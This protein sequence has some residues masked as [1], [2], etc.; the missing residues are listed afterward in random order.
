MLDLESVLGRF[1]NDRTVLEL[2]AGVLRIPTGDAVMSE[3][4]GVSGLTQKAPSMPSSKGVLDAGRHAEEVCRHLDSS[5]LYTGVASAVRTALSLYDAHEEWAVG[6]GDLED[7]HGRDAITRLVGLGL[8]AES[9][10]EGD[11]DSSTS[12]W[13]GTE[14]GRAALAW[15]AAV[16]IVL[17]FSTQDD[18]IDGDKLIDLLDLFFDDAISAWT[19]LT[20]PSSLARSR[21]IVNNWTDALCPAITA[22][23]PHVET[24]ADTVR[25]LLPSD[26]ESH[27]SLAA[28]AESMRLY[29]ALCARHL[30]ETLNGLDS[31]ANE[32]DSA[33]E[34]DNND[35]VKQ[36]MAE[37]VEHVSMAQDA[38]EQSKLQ[39][40]KTEASIEALCGQQDVQVATR[41]KTIDAIESAIAEQKG[42]QGSTPSGD[43]EGLSQQA[44]E[45]QA[46]LVAAEAG[47]QSARSHRDAVNL[48]LTHAVQELEL[49]PPVE[50][51]QSNDVDVAEEK[52]AQ[53]R[54]DL[55][56]HEALV[57]S[58]KGDV[59]A[60]EDRLHAAV[61]RAKARCA[62]VS[63][64][65]E[66][67]R[68]HQA[69][70]D[71]KLS[72]LDNEATTVTA[73]RAKLSEQM[74]RLTAQRKKLGKKGQSAE[75]GVGLLVASVSDAGQE[76]DVALAQHKERQSDCTTKQERLAAVQQAH[77]AVRE[78]LTGTIESELEAAQRTLGIW[79][80]IQRQ[81]T[82]RV[83]LYTA[84]LDIH[85]NQMDALAS[86]RGETKERLL[87][88]RK[89]R[90]SVGRTQNSSSKTVQ[91]KL[92]EIEENQQDQSAARKE[93]KRRLKLMSKAEEDV[94]RM[95][96][97][98]RKREQR[99]VDTHNA[100]LSKEQF[101][102]ELGEQITATR[103][104]LEEI[105]EGQIRWRAAEEELRL[106]EV[107]EVRRALSVAQAEW[108]AADQLLGPLRDAATALNTRLET[109]V[110]TET[111]HTKLLEACR[112]R[113]QEKRDERSV[114]GSRYDHGQ[115]TAK[116]AVEMLKN[117]ARRLEDS[118]LA[119]N[120][121]Q[122]AL[123]SLRSKQG[124]RKASIERWGEQII[125]GQRAE[126]MAKA[127]I[128]SCSEAIEQTRLA[129]SSTADAIGV[130]QRNV[131][132]ARLE[133]VAELGEQIRQ[134]K[135]Q[136]KVVQQ[137]IDE[138]RED[139][140]GLVVA[141]ER[142]VA[143][144][145]SLSTQ[146]Q[147]TKNKIAEV[148]K[149][150]VAHQKRQN[151]VFSV[152][153]E[154]RQGLEAVS[155]G[156]A[157]AQLTIRALESNRTQRAKRVERS[158]GRLTQLDA[159]IELAQ[160]QEEDA[161]EAVADI[162]SWVDRSRL[163]LRRLSEEQNKQTESVGQPPVVPPAKDV[164]TQAKVDKPIH[165]PKKRIPVGLSEIIP[166]PG[167]A[168]DV[169][170]A[171]TMRFV[172]PPSSSETDMDAATAIFDRTPSSSADEVHDE[173]DAATLIF[174]REELRA[175]LEAEEDEDARTSIISIE[176]M[177]AQRNRSKK[178]D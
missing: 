54:R 120:E 57:A 143:S 41:L 111:A 66:R 85:V 22:C 43:L 134:A 141:E 82:S 124:S 110:S 95:T 71:K 59:A 94:V 17:A 166:D 101:V 3:Y 80:E 154:R 102:Q 167:A 8:V 104:A 157:G 74:D 32:L 121:M 107:K 140:A 60:N 105:R 64:S 78:M 50:S 177:K 174:S 168:L 12:M 81:K 152:I 46:K 45:S 164:K 13:L 146:V 9:L 42:M 127:T 160:A 25:L 99:A 159:M 100:V 89:E 114:L 75:D 142:V 151:A 72:V 23:A 38:L 16:E 55:E 112:L 144:Q 61:A 90:R 76:L 88:V 58:A 19:D 40:E 103:A 150:R 137:T 158:L 118:H 86:N 24:I 44:E 149:R 119:R 153:A 6:I 115:K 169:D 97:N 14:S 62:D 84:Q 96:K 77:A 70:S 148:N 139:L 69:E 176:E 122:S 135:T 156:I 163:N 4:G 53:C 125:E 48:A 91:A 162:Q 26:V 27:D 11:S 36:A 172:S 132:E 47:L 128:E 35:A 29:L 92:T 145:S 63:E 7:E 51:L 65:M 73:S 2:L 33:S 123:D 10:C 1:G 113:T 175:T 31:S 155:P 56:E 165:R 116:A 34:T 129:L 106:E 5:E 79:M 117:N 138:A 21:V 131:E 170:E 67:S 18:P 109:A 130:A 161:V 28:E 98:L 147:S 83:S 171:A 52:L 30:G 93:Q 136:I 173:A 37:A 68:N 178:E 108:T 20:S 15:F 126:A 87:A 49:V 39:L 133:R